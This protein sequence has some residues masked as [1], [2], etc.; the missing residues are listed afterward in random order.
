MHMGSYVINFTVYTMAMLGLIFFAI[1]IYK[2]VINGGLCKNSNKFLSVE[3]TMSIN[4]RKS[5]M[6]VR[7][8]NEKFLIASD[9]D[10]TTML[11]KLEGPKKISAQ[12]ILEQ[13]LAKKYERFENTE[14][15]ENFDNLIPK[16][17]I[18][19]DVEKQSQKSM[20]IADLDVVYPQKEHITL[21]PIK[22]KNPQ[23]RRLEKTQM[24]RR[25][26][27]KT[28]NKTVVLDFEKP[29]SHGFSTMKEMAKKIN[30]L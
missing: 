8:G 20:R 17:N 3:E 25:E 21:E 16:E 9:I 11:S 30:E 27:P 14:K 19:I 1:F 15:Y 23:G 26:A 4:P 2:K 12:Q 22:D 29:K 6:V 10:R 28:T 5:I 13:N 24:D 7:A 18:Q